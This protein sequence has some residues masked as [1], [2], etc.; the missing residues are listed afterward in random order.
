MCTH[1]SSELL[2]IEKRKSAWNIRGHGKKEEIM[3]IVIVAKLGRRQIGLKR[4]K[5]NL[6]A[7]AAPG[8]AYY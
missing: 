6:V 3:T 8:F 1:F 4:I 7:K 5:L 2:D